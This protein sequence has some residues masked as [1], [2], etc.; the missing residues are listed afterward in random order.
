MIK[1]LKKYKQMT[2]HREILL[3]EMNERVGNNTIGIEKNLDPNLCIK[4]YI[5]LQ[6]WS[7]QDWRSS[8]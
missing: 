6:E 3:G 2:M 1:N 5:N 8:S 7:T 4:T